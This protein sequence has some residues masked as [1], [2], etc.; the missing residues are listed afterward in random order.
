DRSPHLRPRGG[1]P[2]GPQPAQRPH[3]GAAAGRALL[4]RPA[5]ARRRVAR[6]PA[7]RGGPVRP[8][9]PHRRR[10]RPSR[11]QP[12][13]G[14]RLRHHGRPD[15]RQGA[16]RQRARRAVPARRAALVGDR[17]H[18]GPR[19]RRHGHA[20]RAGP[21]R[22]DPGEPGRQAQVPVAEHRRHALPAAPDRRRRVAALP[23]AA[24]RRRGDRADRPGLRP[25]GRPAARPGPAARAA[26]G[27]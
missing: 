19:G 12:R 14:H 25:P 16:G 26:A 8:R 20:Q 18:P 22:H 7:R 27:L 10:R 6:R 9:L 3:A 5:G 17:G 21:L 24:R 23:G 11:A 4:R 2:P 1:C 13:A 15:R